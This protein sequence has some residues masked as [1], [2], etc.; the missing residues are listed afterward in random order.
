MAQLVTDQDFEEVVLK[1][2][3]PVMVDFFADWCGPCKALMPVVEELATEFDG[4]VKIVKVN[5]DESPE[6][7]Q[8]HGVMSIPNLLF[9]KGG[10]VVDQISGGLPKSKLTEKLSEM[11]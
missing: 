1:S 9:V 10:E 7:A 4:K 8:K 3:I 11:A 5:V 6:A 2:D